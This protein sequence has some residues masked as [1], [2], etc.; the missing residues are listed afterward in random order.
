MR[1]AGERFAA[2]AATSA[3]LRACCLRGEAPT[4]AAYAAAAPAPCFERG[5]YQSTLPSLFDASPAL[6]ALMLRAHYLFFDT[7]FF[8]AAPPCRL[9]RLIF[10][11]ADMPPP[12]I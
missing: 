8:D 3:M 6:D 12:F 5:C 7:Q 9:L 4:P 1:R 10:A 11:A 2:T